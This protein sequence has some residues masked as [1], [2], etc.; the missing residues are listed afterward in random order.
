MKIDKD[1]V[2]SICR[3][4][5]LSEGQTCHEVSIHFVE[6]AT[7]CELHDEYFQDPSPTDCISFPIDDET[8]TEWRILGEIFISPKAALDYS[9]DKKLNSYEELTLYLVH[10]LLHLLGYDDKEEKER[11]IMRSKEASKLALLKEKELLLTD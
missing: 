8:E 9:S 1:L 7:I 2:S 4:V 5:V 10:G 11:Q 3:E 6:E